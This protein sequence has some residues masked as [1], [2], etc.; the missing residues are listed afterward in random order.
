MCDLKLDVASCS[1]D[2]QDVI[3]LFFCV[4]SVPELFKTAKLLQFVPV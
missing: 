2:K 3:D 4:Y 1:E